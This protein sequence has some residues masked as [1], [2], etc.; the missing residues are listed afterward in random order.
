MTFSLKFE[1]IVI[2]RA[3]VVDTKNSKGNKLIKKEFFPTNY[4]YYKC[5]LLLL[6]VLEIDRG[7]FECPIGIR[8]HQFQ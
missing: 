8:T 5:L 1:C 4:Y 7:D 2:E 3:K 6:Q